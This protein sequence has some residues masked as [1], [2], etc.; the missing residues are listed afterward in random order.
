MSLNVTA[1][2]WVTVACKAAVGVLFV[3]SNIILCSDSVSLTV[4]GSLDG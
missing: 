4:D 1:E 3:K 2:R